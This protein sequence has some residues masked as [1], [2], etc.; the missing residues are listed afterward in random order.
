MLVPL[1]S[2]YSIHQGSN[3]NLT[4]KTTIQKCELSCELSWFYSVNYRLPKPC[5]CAAISVDEDLFSLQ[6]LPPKEILVISSESRYSW[7]LTY[8]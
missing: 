5:F 2:L 8:R 6:D 3:E 7:R 4:I 1:E